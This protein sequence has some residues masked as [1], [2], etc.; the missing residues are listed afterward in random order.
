MSLIPHLRR[1]AAAA[2]LALAWSLAAAA[3]PSPDPP[4]LQIE[5]GMHT[6]PI[7]QMRLDTQRNRLVTVGTDRTA[8]VWQL[9]Q[10]KLVQTLRMPAAPGFEGELH[11][12]AISADSRWL[13]VGGTTG[14]RW[15]QDGCIHVYALDTLRL[16]RSVCGWPEIVQTLGFSRD[17]RW[18]AV[19]LGGRLG[20]RIVRTS[21]WTEDPAARDPEYG[22][23][24]RYVEWSV[25]GVLASSAGDGY[26]RLYSSELKR[27]GR[28]KLGE[29][30]QLGGVRFTPDGTRMAVGTADRP[31]MFIV[32]TATMATVATRTVDDPRQRDLCCIGYSVDGRHLYV[33]GTYA[34]TGATPARLRA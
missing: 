10:L 15:R 18:L 26:L 19:G 28:R 8:R 12:I 23:A 21:D 3:A 31:Q 14:F 11:A 16:A 1:L 29:S 13:A 32:D 33:N 9:P 30:T 6:A 22:G 24:V 20:L 7:Q 34:G 25:G 17:G 4:M 2:P 5:G 27:I